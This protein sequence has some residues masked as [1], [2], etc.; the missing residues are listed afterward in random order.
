MTLQNKRIVVT[1]APHQ[2]VKLAEMLQEKGAV[3]LMYPCIDIAPPADLAPLDAV[4]RNLHNY[5]WLLITSS[6]TPLAM[7]RRL[8]A[9]EII[10]D[11]VHLKIAAVG[12]TTAEAMETLFGVKAEIV[13]ETQS[14]AALAEVIN[15]YEK[16]RVLLPQASI[17]KPD[18][19][20]VLRKRG[21]DV[22]VVEAYETVIGH[23]G[24]D[25]PTMIAENRVDAVTF[26]SSST[27]E[28]F[29]ERI[30]PQTATHLPVVCIGAPTSDTAWEAG[31]QTVIASQDYSLENMVQKLKEYFAAKVN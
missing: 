31:F 21:A 24:E 16:M 1:R 23:G 28:N 9:L 11:F 18:L 6:N 7:K 17:A 4:L 26:T 20:D 15:V 12:Q 8:Q 13:P 22:T 14:A 10:P 30:K 3:P 29:V 5:E 2:A 19:A 25:I 27:V